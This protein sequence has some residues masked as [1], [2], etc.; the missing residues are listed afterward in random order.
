MVASSKSEPNC[1]KDAISLYW[2]NS[3]FKEP[4]I[5][6]HWFLIELQ[7][8]HVLTDNPT[9]IAGLFLYKINSVSK[10]IWPSVIEITFVGI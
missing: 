7:N 1:A 6:F 2:A 3:N 8:Q 10:K 9:L 5:L 4:A